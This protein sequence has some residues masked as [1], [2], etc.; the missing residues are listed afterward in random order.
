MGAR[1]LLG[2]TLSICLISGSECAQA[3][4]ATGTTEVLPAIEVSPPP[5]AAKPGQARNPRPVAQNLRRVLVYP[6]APTPTAG[7]GMDVDNVPAGINALGAPQIQRT[8]SLNTSDALQP[9]PP[10]AVATAV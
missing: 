8:R 7:S 3:Q 10:A 2:G 1:F 6:T 9:Q 5:T 4:S